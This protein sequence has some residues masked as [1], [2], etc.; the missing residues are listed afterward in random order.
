M[1]VVDAKDRQVA[2]ALLGGRRFR[3]QC[4]A[5]FLEMSG[6]HIRIGAI[7]NLRESLVG[8]EP[9]TDLVLI[10]TRDQSCS[11]PGVRRILASL[12][13][14]LPGVPVTVVS[15]REDRSAVLDALNLGVR[16]YFPS[17]LDP[18]ILPD[19]LRFVQGGGTYIPL[20][21]LTARAQS[22]EGRRTSRWA[23]LTPGEERVLELLRTG[24]SNKH[25]ARE[26]N[27]R[28]GTVKVHVR[29]IMKKL[30]AA[31]RTQAALAAQQIAAAASRCGSTSS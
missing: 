9:A 2:V 30:N 24:Q 14:V 17:S 18:D 4:L 27:L 28:E 12:R 25:I 16:A 8:Q 1:G 21:V 3:E 29:R 31:N 19:T 11:D 26:L 6:F 22:P 20:G 23:E 7:D 15:D 10:D 13:D 5:R